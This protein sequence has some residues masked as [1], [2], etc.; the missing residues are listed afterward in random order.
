MVAGV[1]WGVGLGKTMEE[2]MEGSLEIIYT[3][4]IAQTVCFLPWGAEFA[5]HL[6]F[7]C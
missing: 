1:G 7:L 4:L 6:N 3:N 5:E 2:P